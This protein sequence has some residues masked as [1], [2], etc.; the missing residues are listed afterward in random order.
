MVDR[1]A[2]S[3]DDVCSFRS[4]REPMGATKKMPGDGLLHKYCLNNGDNALHQWVQSRMIP[5]ASWSAKADHPRLAVL[6]SAKAWMVGLRR[7]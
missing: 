4:L 1:L 6:V 2:C 7:P 3:G 5:T